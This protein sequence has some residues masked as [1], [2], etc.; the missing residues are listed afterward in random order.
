MFKET[1]LDE[2][3]A[4]SRM[5]WKKTRPLGSQQ[6]STLGGLVHVDGKHLFFYVPKRYRDS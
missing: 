4:P 1:S 6:K 2:F 5:I 3:D